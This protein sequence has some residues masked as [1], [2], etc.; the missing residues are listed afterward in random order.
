[1]DAD[2]MSPDDVH[3]SD[4]FLR[5]FSA[6]TASREEG[7]QISA[8]LLASVPNGT[9]LE[10]FHP[11][12]DPMFYALVANRSAFDNGYYQVPQGSGFGIE[13]DKSVIE[14]YRV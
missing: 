9:Y 2:I 13:M 4:D 12:R 3:P 14:K 10:T 8:H 6:G 1:M 11:H 5:R 7:R